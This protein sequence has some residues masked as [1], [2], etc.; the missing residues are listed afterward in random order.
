MFKI[1]ELENDISTLIGRLDNTPDSSVRQ[2][3]EQKIERLLLSQI[4]NRIKELDCSI[5][6]VDRSIELL[7]QSSVRMER[8][9]KRLLWL[10]VVL[11]I[12]A[13]IAA[14]PIVRDL[15]HYFRP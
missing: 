15:V 11:A 12:L 9:T 7:G 2:A 4:E 14:I 3:I 13:G 6:R 10:T 5:A 8:F 1:G